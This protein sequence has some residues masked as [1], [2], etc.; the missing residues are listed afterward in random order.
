MRASA[1]VYCVTTHVSCPPPF[2]DDRPLRLLLAR[3]IPARLLTRTRHRLAPP[4]SVTGECE[5]SSPNQDRTWVTKRTTTKR[6]W[7]GSRR[8]SSTHRWY[9]PDT[10]HPTNQRRKYM[11]NTGR[12][13][14]TSPSFRPCATR[15]I[16]MLPIHARCAASKYIRT[17]HAG[18]AVSKCTLS[19]RASASA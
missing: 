8:Q 3:L 2:A 9:P 7:S 5:Q 12:L 10:H 4:P 1:R 15:G 13:H 11:P 18:R 19:V 6:T 16:L 17:P 14:T